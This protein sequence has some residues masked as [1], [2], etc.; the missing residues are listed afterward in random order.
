MK[1]Q[2]IDW[3]KD[4]LETCLK[5]MGPNKEE[6]TTNEIDV[7]YFHDIESI[8]YESDV[9]DIFAMSDDELDAELAALEITDEDIDKS[10]TIFTNT[11]ILNFPL[12]KTIRQTATP[13]KI[14]SISAFEDKLLTT[15]IRQ[16]IDCKINA[17]E[18][19]TFSQNA[20]GFNRTDPIS[21]EGNI[22]PFLNNEGAQK[23]ATGEEKKEFTDNR[24][25]SFGKA[26]SILAICATALI[27]G[28]LVDEKPETINNNDVVKST[29]QPMQKAN[30]LP[31]IN[32]TSS[33][34]S[35]DLEGSVIAEA[36]APSISPEV[37]KSDYIQQTGV[38]R[39]PSIRM[40]MYT[41]KNGLINRF[42][43]TGS[44]EGNYLAKQTSI[45]ESSP[46]SYAVTP[47]WEPV[48]TRH[49]LQYDATMVFLDKISN[50]EIEATSVERL[51]ILRKLLDVA[52]SDALQAVL[53][54]KDYQSS[55]TCPAR[56]LYEHPVS[57]GDTISGIILDECLYKLTDSTLFETKITLNIGDIVLINI[58]ENR[59]VNKVTVSRVDGS[60]SKI[61]NTETP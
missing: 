6:N 25:V 31:S 56:G 39:S 52:K 14:K 55:D 4:V 10:L 18:N 19:P 60:I 30:S 11:D 57:S 27:A 8:D 5:A 24:R 50:G 54:G 47:R 20:A 16:A 35:W 58:A 44:Q 1:Q 13:L 43:K 61:Y 38:D 22:L 9:E 7:R 42:I 15:L 48:N 49:I 29:L 37:K 33:R 23:L 28:S 2:T 40:F 12:S 3:A 46:I 21:S 53:A 32:T 26:A 45:G 59:V 34:I 41:S 17:I 51:K 36:N